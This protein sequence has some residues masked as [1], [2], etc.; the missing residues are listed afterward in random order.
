MGFPHSDTYGS[1]LVW[2]LT[3]LFRGLNRPSSPACPKASTSCPESLIIHYLR[4]LILNFASQILSLRIFADL[5]CLLILSL[6]AYS[7]ISEDLF[8]LLNLSSQ[9]LILRSIYSAQSLLSIQISL[10]CS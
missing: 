6:F 2:Q 10:S 5:S 4:S 9:S 8:S 1:T 7:Q 3:V